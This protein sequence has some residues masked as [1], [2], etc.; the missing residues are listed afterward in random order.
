[1][2]AHGAIVTAEI[3]R[4]SAVGTRST[5]TLV[6]VQIYLIVNIALDEIRD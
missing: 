1:M 6:I 2:R 4:Q 3:L 5:A